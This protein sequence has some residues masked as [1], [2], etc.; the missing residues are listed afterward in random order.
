MAFSQLKLYCISTPHQK[1]SA[2][3]W[4]MFSFSKGQNSSNTCRIKNN[5]GN[6]IVP[7][8]AVSCL[9]T[10][11]VKLCRNPCS[12]HVFALLDFT[13]TLSLSSLC[14]SH[15]MTSL[16]PCKCVSFL[17][18]K[19]TRLIYCSASMRIFFSVWFAALRCF[20]KST[21]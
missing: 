17:A 11:Q 16:L 15:V 19:E 5:S 1:S 9:C 21:F 10:L 8:T 2:L 14:S 7:K 18:R 4:L 6:K 13:L 12:L 3:F 20:S